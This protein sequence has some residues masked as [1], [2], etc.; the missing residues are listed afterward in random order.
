M[1]K[2]FEVKDFNSF[3]EAISQS[4]PDKSLLITNPVKAIDYLSLAYFKRLL[5]N[6]EHVNFSF[7]LNSDNDLTICLEAIDLSFGY[8]VFSGNEELVDKLKNRAEKNKSL[9]FPTLDEAANFTI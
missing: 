4:S 6:F 7:I 1:K 9:I 8:I 2:I 5:S 3:T